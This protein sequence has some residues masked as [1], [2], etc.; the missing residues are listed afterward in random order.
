MASR[1]A[2][3]AQFLERGELFY[4]HGGFVTRALAMQWAEA[5]RTA[6]ARGGV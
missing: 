1:T 5:E 2:G 4:S 6:M 3:K